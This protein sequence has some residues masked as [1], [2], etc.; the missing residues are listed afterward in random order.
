LQAPLD[1]LLA[2]QLYG[3]DAHPTQV[4]ADAMAE[5]EDLR[6]A[7]ADDRPDIGALQWELE[8][9]TNIGGRIM[10][11]AVDPEIDDTIF[12]AAASGGVWRSDDAG[13]TFESVWPDHLTQAI[14]AL[15]ITPEGVL[16]AG[17]G[18]TGPGGGSMTYGGTGVYRSTDRGASWEFVGLEK[19]SRIGR[20]VVHPEDSQ[21]IYV[22]ASGPLFYGG[23]Q[24]GLYRST[25]GGNT[26]ERILK[27][28]N[29]TTG[30]VDLAINP[31][32]P[33]HMLAAMW[34]HQREP[35]IRR[36]NGVGSG[37][38][39]THDAGQT[40]DRV[41]TGNFG[42]NPGLGRIGVAFA[43]SDGNVVYVTAS[44]ESGAY[45]GFSK[46]VD[47]GQTWIPIADPGVV[48]NNVVYGWW[49]GRVW[50]DPQDPDHV[51]QAGLYL[52]ESTNGGQTFTGLLNSAN[53]HADQHAMAWDPK[54]PGR[55]YL[56]ND[57]GVYRSDDNG[58][59]NRPWHFGSYQ[60]FSQLYGLDV[61]EQN[62]QRQVA[63]L[64][65]NGVNRSFDSQDN[66]GG[67]D[68]WNSYGG[69]DGERT[70]INPVNG[71]IVY[72]C[73]QYGSCFVSHDGG[74][75][76]TDFSNKVISSR[77]NWFTPIEFDPAD[78]SIVYS[79]GEFMSRSTDDAANWT[80]I[81]PDLSNGPGRET[82]PLFINFGTLTTIAPAA[83][84]TEPDGTIYAGTDDGNLWFTHDGAT[85]WTKAT[86]ADL[87]DRWV[88]RVEVD[89]RDDQTA[90][91]TYSG[92]RN[93]DDTPYVFRTTDGG[94]NWT[95]ITGN[96][97]EAP[98]NDINVIGD[99][100]V[101]AG[102]L[103]V[104]LS[105]DGGRSWYPLGTGLPNAPV[106]ELRWHEPTSALYA[107]TFGRGLYRVE[108]DSVLAGA[109][110]DS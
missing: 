59:S 52:A 73:S 41:R 48:A 70:L 20:I 63:G 38:Y 101:V 65:D 36:Y 97:P 104:Y 69:G 33:D 54:V 43:P 35:D 107:A 5:A 89:P 46:S 79:G 64:Q 21:T 8:G 68:G 57:G 22:A 76:K 103:G 16:F 74:D 109:V 90:Y 37:L 34:D 18:E 71:Q 28:D 106:H 67:P 4:Y 13:D 51:F 105:D 49:F 6:G 91:V 81:S 55:V 40:W 17:T 2:R 53:V 95:D 23:G 110:A 3:S 102:D 61:D 99:V 14:G 24:R 82:N 27:G 87:P 31:D 86:D 11:V 32:N 30:A 60:P 39:V 1:A 29:P 62:P 58:L 10:D 7:V 56:G 50:V 100:L 94:V 72:G 98:Y 45:F 44:G 92:F 83:G 78:P 85:T 108:L 80:V 9:P 26:W 19:S 75:R 96:L 66:I 93:G 88:T 77:K 25:D 84:S 12:A 47:G 15:T 42:P